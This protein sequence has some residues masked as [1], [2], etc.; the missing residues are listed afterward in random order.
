MTTVADSTF[1]RAALAAE[2]DPGARL[3]LIEQTLRPPE[4]QLLD[5][6]VL[7]NLDWV[8]RLLETRGSIIWDDGAVDD[9]A[10]RY[11]PH[12]ANDLVDLGILY[13]EFENRSGYP[14]LVS[15]TVQWEVEQ[16]GGIKGD[17]LRSL[18]QFFRGHQDDISID[19]YPGIAQGLL[20]RVPSA[21]VSPLLLR[22]L[23][24]SSVD[25]V[26]SES[27]PLRFLRDRGDRTI[28]GE[29]LVS[30]IPVLLTTDR[31]TFWRHRGQLEDMGLAVMRPTEL[32]KLYE[33]YWEALDE[34][35][36][37]R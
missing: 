7:Q 20:F 18:L 21:R 28:A 17:R 30:N 19:A 36:R 11:G 34:E 26:H 23:G 32:L 13:K 27:G 8:D 24:V 3:G 1:L 15:R 37:R 31:A 16:A 12:L 2:G 9:L 5:T 29:A 25:E 35:F 22:G 33:P 4:P 10:Q 14:W 6:S